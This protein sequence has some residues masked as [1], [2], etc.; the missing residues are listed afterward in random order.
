MKSLI[1]AI[2]VLI[3]LELTGC[4]T[5]PVTQKFPEAPHKEVCE[6]LKL[7]PENALLSQVAKIIAENYVL[8]HEC[9]IRNSAWIDWYDRQAKLFKELK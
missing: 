3:I 4:T 5:V 1:I 7:L 6:P 9:A 2:F 8:Y